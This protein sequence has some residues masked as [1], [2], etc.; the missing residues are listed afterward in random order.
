MKAGELWPELKESW[1]WPPCMHALLSPE[2]G[3]CFAFDPA[4]RPSAE[5]V[6]AALEAGLR[7]DD[8]SDESARAPP[9]GATRA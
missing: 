5:E 4:D 7:D 8:I 9:L 6:L 2:A 3:G 1:G